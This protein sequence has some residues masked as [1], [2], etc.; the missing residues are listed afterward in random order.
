MIYKGSF[1]L[2]KIE[3]TSSPST[4]LKFPKKYLYADPFQNNLLDNQ[5]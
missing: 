1:F 2:S 3:I 4:G 5:L